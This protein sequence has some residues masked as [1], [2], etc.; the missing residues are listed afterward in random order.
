[1]DTAVWMISRIGQADRCF[2][3]TKSLSEFPLL[4]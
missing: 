4:G 1:M 3:M 2:G